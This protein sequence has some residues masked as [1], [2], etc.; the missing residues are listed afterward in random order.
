MTMKFSTSSMQTTG[1]KMTKSSKYQY[2]PEPATKF[3]TQIGFRI[4]G[5]T[6]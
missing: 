3:E 1:A 4:L 2:L 5:K 6:N